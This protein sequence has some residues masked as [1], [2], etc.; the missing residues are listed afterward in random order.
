VDKLGS[1][2]SRRFRRSP[3]PRIPLT[4][5]ASHL[6]APPLYYEGVLSRVP[7][8]GFC[9]WL[10]LVSSSRRSTPINPFTWLLVVG[11]ASLVWIDP[12]TAPL[13]RQI[14][15]TSTTTSSLYV[16]SRIMIARLSSS[17]DRSCYPASNTF[18]IQVVTRNLGMSDGSASP[19]L[20]PCWNLD[21]PH[22]GCQ[23][24][25]NDIVHSAG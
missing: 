14:G 18:V 17:D 5:S 4:L 13:S 25:R 1:W 16:W 21:L 3:L 20:E 23:V 19:R 12:G 22:V 24:N 9:P 15:V 2:P 10:R 7:R 6:Q 11:K 8:L